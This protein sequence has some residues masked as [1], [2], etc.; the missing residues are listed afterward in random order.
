MEDD[1]YERITDEVIERMEDRRWVEKHNEHLRNIEDSFLVG[2]IL[3]MQH[4]FKKGIR[5]PR[6]RD[7]RKELETRSD[8]STEEKLSKLEAHIHNIRVSD[9]LSDKKEDNGVLSEGII[10]KPEGR[11]R[12]M[13]R[14][15][16]KKLR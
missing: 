5:D 8:L 9:E 15:I 12:K 14:R 1:D 3:I 7:Y 4:E 13:L 10:P 16:K 2:E 11:I 6:V